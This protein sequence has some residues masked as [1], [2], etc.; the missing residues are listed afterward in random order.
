MVSTLLL[1]DY[2]V[3]YVSVDLFMWLNANRNFLEAWFMTNY[4]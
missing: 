2:C 4:I 1:L 3:L